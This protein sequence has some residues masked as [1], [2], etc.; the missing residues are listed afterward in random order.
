VDAWARDR[1]TELLPE[2]Q[3]FTMR[4]D[5]VAAKLKLSQNRTPGDRLGVLDALA[6]SARDD[7]HAVRDLMAARFD[8]SGQL[9]REGGR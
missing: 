5:G 3:A 1:T 7:D 4:V 9:P 6:S 2:L 8:E